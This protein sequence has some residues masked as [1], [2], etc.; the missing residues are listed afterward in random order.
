MVMSDYWY[1]G[2]L[3]TPMLTTGTCEQGYYTAGDGTCTICDGGQ[4]AASTV[5]IGIA[6]LMCIAVAVFLA[7]MTYYLKAVFDGTKAP[8]SFAPTAGK[9]SACAYSATLYTYIQ[10]NAVLYMIQCC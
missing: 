7:G 8:P 9:P 3:L 1:T 4:A 10:C 2:C 6:V 5:R